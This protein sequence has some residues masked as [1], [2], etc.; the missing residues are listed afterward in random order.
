[1]AVVKMTSGGSKNSSY[2]VSADICD[3]VDEVKRVGNELIVDAGKCH[4]YSL[5]HIIAPPSSV[6]FPCHLLTFMFRAHYAER[7]LVMPV[8]AANTSTLYLLQYF[9]SRGIWADPRVLDP[10]KLETAMQMDETKGEAPIVV[11]HAAVEENKVAPIPHTVYLHIKAEETTNESG[12]YRCFHE[13][14]VSLDPHSAVL[15]TQIT[16]IRYSMPGQ[17][18]R[19]ADHVLSEPPFAFKLGPCWGR[20][21]VTIDI[22]TVT[23]Q[24]FKSV[25]ESNLP[26]KSGV[27]PLK[28]T[29]ATT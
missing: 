2:T 19:Q 15:P 6:K 9:P 12:K 27:V 18:F 26:S 13:L 1:M 5:S 8:P 11:V 17:G 21:H 22:T 3:A 16:A 14:S 29:P 28:L 25:Y 10:A 20:P 23:G 4:G 24:T 7:P